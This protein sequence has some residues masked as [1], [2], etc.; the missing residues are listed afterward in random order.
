MAQAINTLAGLIQFNDA[1]NDDINVSDLLDDSPLLQVLFAK[2]ASNGTQHKYMKQTIA[3]ASAFRA[4]N[5]GLTKT[6]SQDEQVTDTLKILDGSFSVDKALADAYR[7]GPEAYVAKELMRTMRQRLFALESQ[8]INGVNADAN[9]FVGLADDPQLDKTGDTMC[10]AAATAGSTADSQTSVYLLRSGDDDVAA[11]MGN[12]GQMV[13]SD[14]VVV[15]I[16]DSA[17]ALTTYSAYYTG[18]EGYA[19][20]Q[21]GGAYSAA[22]ICNIETALIDEDFSNAISLFPAARQPNLIVLNRKALKLYRDSLTATS[23]TGAPAPFPT[24]IFGIPVVVSDGVTV[25]EAVVAAS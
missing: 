25:T 20:F 1:N 22:R 19:G 3:S 6:Y 15:P 4:V 17:S 14:T 10:V 13:V 24:E 11:I 18:V 23:A 12:E 16:Y 2:A 21:I 5:S 9:G 7:L 8:I